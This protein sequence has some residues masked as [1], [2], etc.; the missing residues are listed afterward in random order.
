MLGGGSL[1][2]SL[3]LTET[4]WGVGGKQRTSPLGKSFCL[5]HVAHPEAVPKRMLLSSLL[6][7]WHLWRGSGAEEGFTPWQEQ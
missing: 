4:V 2:L 7:R 3:E 6:E 5:F 1:S